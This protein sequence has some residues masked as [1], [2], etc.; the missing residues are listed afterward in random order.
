L[1][2]RIVL[3]TLKAQSSR[4]V[5]SVAMSRP[6]MGAKFC[7]TMRTAEHLGPLFNAMPDDPAAAVIAHRRQ[8]MN[9]ALE[10]IEDMSL[11]VHDDLE[12]FV[13]LIATDF[14]GSHG[15]LL[16][17]SAMANDANAIPIEP[18]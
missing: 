2:Q 17:T 1:H 8:G 18:R 9:R 14:A 4:F 15:K 16:S 13:V 5:R 11:A 7:R 10:T 6:Y 3:A 12:A